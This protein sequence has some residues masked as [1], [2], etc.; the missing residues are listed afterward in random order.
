MG[1]SGVASARSASRARQASR[2]PPSA[3]RI[4]SSARRPVGP[5]RLRPTTTSVRWPTTSRPSRIHDRRASSRR[6][7]VDAATA[8]VSSRPR[9][10]GS[11]MISRTPARRASAASRSRRLARLGGRLGGWPLAR[12][13]GGPPRTGRP[14]RTGG[15]LRASA[16]RS[17]TRTS[18]DRPASSE[19]AMAMPSSGVSGWR[20]TSH[21]SRTPRATASTGSRLR[22]RSTQAAI[23]PPAWASA[24]RRSATVVCP[25]DG[26]PHRATAAS[27]GTPPGPRIASR[28]A[29]PVPITR[30][31]S[32]GRDSG[33]NSGATASVPITRGAAAPQRVRRDARAA[34][35]SGERLAMGH[36]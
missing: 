3:Y 29:K 23:A 26:A 13:A 8:A 6:S 9:P 2:P 36:R 16:G 10:G 22:A 20:T 30:S 32:A 14:L 18:T 33:S 21:S 5:N 7:A 17:M 25:L 11:R 4:R 24:T 27:R 19:P 15:S 28:A 35:T 1:A 12:P 31:V 34:E